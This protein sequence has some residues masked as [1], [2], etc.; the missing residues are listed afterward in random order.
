MQFVPSLAAFTRLALG[1]YLC[2]GFAFGDLA[3]GVEDG[4]GG[5]VAALRALRLAF[6]RLAF[7]IVIQ[8]RVCWSLLL[9][10]VSLVFPPEVVQDCAAAFNREV[11]AASG[12]GLWRRLEDAWEQLLER[13]GASG[14][15]R[16]DSTVAVGVRARGRSWSR[17]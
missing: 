11:V 3:V 9:V 2:H 10:L 12:K 14:V 15:E 4:R 13:E 8:D 1:G 7:Q 6:G 5:Q 16:A 17:V